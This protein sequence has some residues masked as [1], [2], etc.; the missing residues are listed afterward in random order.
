M[1]EIAEVV[2]TP[3]ST[4][5]K[6]QKLSKMEKGVFCTKGLAA[7]NGKILSAEHSASCMCTG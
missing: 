5:L 2:K 7:T 6:L 1:F 3:R 4:C